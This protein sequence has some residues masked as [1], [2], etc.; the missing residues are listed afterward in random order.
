MLKFIESERKKFFFFVNSP[1]KKF[2]EKNKENMLKLL[3]QKNKN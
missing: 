1:R 3:K 2:D